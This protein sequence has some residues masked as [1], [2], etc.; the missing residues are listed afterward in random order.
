MVNRMTQGEAEKI[1][2]ITAPYTMAD[3]KKTHRRHMATYH[4][5]KFHSDGADGGMTKDEAEKVFI[6][7][8]HAYDVLK[9]LFKNRPDDYMVTPESKRAA[10]STSST[11]DAHAHAGG[12]NSY[13]STYGTPYGN[14][15]G[16]AYGN[17]HGNPSGSSDGSA[18]YGRPDG[19]D[20]WSGYARHGA[21]PGSDGA[22]TSDTA[23]GNAATK[24]KNQKKKSSSKKKNTKKKA[25]KQ[26]P[27]ND[28]WQQWQPDPNNSYSP[29]AEGKK[30]LWTW[31]VLM[32]TVVGFAFWCHAEPKV[33]FET[34]VGFILNPF[35]LAIFLAIAFV[36]PY[37]MQ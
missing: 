10:S 19:Y 7:G 24:K 20:P 37:F 13:E 29:S 30:F 16:S 2:G 8:N 18:S 14:P 32:G 22:T 17:P 28:E 27:A 15:H 11:H 12:A 25:T 1:L 21:S 36:P 33:A 6:S 3:L 31:F 5:D 34:A 9:D 35:K 26:K 23:T 4:P